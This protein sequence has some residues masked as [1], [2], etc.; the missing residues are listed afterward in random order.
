MINECYDNEKRSTVD[1]NTCKI[2]NLM[3]G[4]SEGKDVN[5]NGFYQGDR[6]IVN[7]NIMILDIGAGNTEIGVCEGAEFIY[8]NTIPLGGDNITSD[9]AY[10]FNLS[11]DEADR[12]KRQ[13]RACF[14]IFYR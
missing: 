7:D 13:Y 14:K 5:D 12:L 9:I 3:Q 6:Y 1:I 11:E 10:V 4:R 8:T 2:L